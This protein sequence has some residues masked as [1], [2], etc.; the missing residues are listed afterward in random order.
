MGLVSGGLLSLE[1]VGVGECGCT[2]AFSICLQI[3][4]SSNAD[5]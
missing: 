5:I 2:A 3:V 4:H 1:G